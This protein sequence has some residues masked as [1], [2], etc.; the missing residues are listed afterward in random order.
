MAVL[1]YNANAVGGGRLDMSVTDGSTGADLTIKGTDRSSEATVFA[2]GPS[3][4]M[5]AAKCAAIVAGVHDGEQQIDIYSGYA[6]YG[7]NP[8]GRLSLLPA[9][10]DSVVVVLTPA[11]G[12]GSAG[13]EVDRG[14]LATF[15]TACAAAGHDL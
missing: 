2:G 7:A 14:Q 9:G 6:G 4:L 5:I 3:L 8:E 12:S 10:S 15:G 1:S 11:T 13:V